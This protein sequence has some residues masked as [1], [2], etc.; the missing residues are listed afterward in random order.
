[1]SFKI[2]CLIQIKL[3]KN[4]II[5]FKNTDT[6]TFFICKNTTSIGLT[7]KYCMPFVGYIYFKG[8]TSLLG[9]F[10]IV[11]CLAEVEKLV[12]TSDLEISKIRVLGSF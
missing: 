6:C 10:N 4:L 8:V 11:R 1:M 5:L 12:W 9:L 3:M 7:E 2:A